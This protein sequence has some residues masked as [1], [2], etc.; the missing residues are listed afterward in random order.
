MRCSSRVTE[1]NLLP[2]ADATDGA[3]AAAFREDFDVVGL[4]GSRREANACCSLNFFNGRFYQ[5]Q[6]GCG[7]WMN[8]SWWT[9]HYIRFRMTYNSLLGWWT[10]QSLD[11]SCSLATVLRDL[12]THFCQ[13]L[14]M[15]LPIERCHLRTRSQVLPDLFFVWLLYLDYRQAVKPMFQ[16][17]GWTNKSLWQASWWSFTYWNKTE[18]LLAKIL[19]FYRSCAKEVT[20][21]SLLMDPPIML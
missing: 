10:E 15:A 2:A 16:Q 19:A 7:F 20:K 4:V 3:R 14:S 13:F 21:I 18:W 9:I 17:P 6:I 12:S 5:V 8:I 11:R 1:R